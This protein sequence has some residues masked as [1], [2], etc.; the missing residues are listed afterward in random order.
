MERL[1]RPTMAHPSFFP[2]GSGTASC[3]AAAASFKSA[4]ATR[5]PA[6]PWLILPINPRRVISLSALCVIS[7]LLLLRISLL[8]QLFQ[9]PLQ[10][11]LILL[12]QLWVAW[13]AINLA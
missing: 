12:L 3:C 1:P 4:P 2:G 11:L 6:T 5:T 10:V 9:A 13:G 8:P 7:V